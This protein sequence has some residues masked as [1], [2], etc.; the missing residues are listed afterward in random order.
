M[1]CS[2]NLPCRLTQQSFEILPNRHT[3]AFRLIPP[4][5]LDTIS[6]LL[7]YF[8]E[9]L[10]RIMRHS[11]YRFLQTLLTC[12]PLQRWLS[13]FIQLLDQPWLRRGCEESHAKHNPYYGVKV[14]TRPNQKRV[15]EAKEN[16]RNGGEAKG[17]LCDQVRE[18]VIVTLVRRRVLAIWSEKERT[19]VSAEISKLSADADLVRRKRDSLL[20][21]TVCKNAA[22]TKVR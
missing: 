3:P 4:P 13:L 20:F 16:K 12:R 15:G 1:S 11:H 19:D 8:V 18:D 9:V 10:R 22:K 17:E 2:G 7:E 5:L 6:Q 14:Y 21:A